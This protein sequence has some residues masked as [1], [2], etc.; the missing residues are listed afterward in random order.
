MHWYNTVDVFSPDQEEFEMN[1]KEQPLIC[2]THVNVLGEN[3]HTTRKNTETL[4]DRNQE[5][6]LERNVRK[7]N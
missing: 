7:K 3:I 5:R 2:A 1:R 6:C 4:V